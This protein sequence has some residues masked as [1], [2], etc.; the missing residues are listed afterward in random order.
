MFNER[1][2]EM[3]AFLVFNVRY[4]KQYGKKYVGNSTR[5]I[6]MEMVMMMMMM[7]VV[8]MVMVV[9]VVMMVMV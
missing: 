3:A 2:Y 6:K 7:M 1:N 5:M 9:M 8:M 4:G